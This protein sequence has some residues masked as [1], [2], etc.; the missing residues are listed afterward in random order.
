M[1]DITSPGS[2]QPGSDPAD[3]G[4]D[5]GGLGPEE[6]ELAVKRRLQSGT[7]SSDLSVTEYGSCMELG[8]EPVGFVQGFC[9]MQVTQYYSSGYWSYFSPSSGGYF[10]Q[11]SCPHGFVSA[12][13]RTYGYNGEMVYN[14][15]GWR[16]GFQSAYSRML[17]EASAA[18]AHGVIGVA[19]TVQNLV[20][21]SIK[22]FHLTGTAVRLKGLDKVPSIFTTFLAGQR[23]VKL[24]EAGFMPV[25]VVS[26]LAEI[27]V[28]AYCIT[29]ALAEGRYGPGWP[30]GLGFGGM[31]MG[32][33]RALGGG[34]GGGFSGGF[35][36]GFGG[37]GAPGGNI[38]SPGWPSQGQSYSSSNWQPQEI[39]QISE[40]YSEAY[41]LANDLAAKALAGDTL[42]GASM[43]IDGH[44]SGGGNHIVTCSLEGTRVRK[45]SHF[46]HLDP[47]EP[48]VGLWR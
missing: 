12:E 14:E 34:M 39:D 27:A 5:S 1:T 6:V 25:S 20:D 41:R 26:T 40:A 15:A 38:A 36:G 23:L 9:A 46:S 29:E 31:G 18:G 7:F 24:V 47:P 10:R 22:E 16:Q 2:D 44:E 48:V 3:S 37:G 43:Q 45:F 42:H 11:Y 8:L 19:H 35:G 33:G 32:L 4:S 30:A 13:H 21:A 17:E 28:F